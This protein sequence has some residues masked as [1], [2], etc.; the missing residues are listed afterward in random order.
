MTDRSFIVILRWISVIPAAL[1]AQLITSLIMPLTIG[2]AASYLDFEREGIIPTLA[3]HGAMAGSMATIGSVTA[4]K[5][6]K[7]TYVILG[8]LNLTA[9][10][11]LKYGTFEI[12]GCLIGLVLSYTQASDE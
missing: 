9:Y 4:P 2:F 5:F 7:V 1:L 6:R 10:V 3:L 8:I 12:V 11:Y